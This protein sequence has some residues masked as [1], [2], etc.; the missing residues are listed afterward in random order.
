MVTILLNMFTTIV[1]D[2]YGNATAMKDNPETLEEANLAK[3]DSKLRFPK[4]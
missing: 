1:I 4:D 3:F 2:A